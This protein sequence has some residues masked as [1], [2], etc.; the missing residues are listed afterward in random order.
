MVLQHCG[1]LSAK[2]EGVFPHLFHLH[3]SVMIIRKRNIGFK[4]K[5]EAQDIKPLD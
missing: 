4:I 5:K 1:H 2:N 3:T